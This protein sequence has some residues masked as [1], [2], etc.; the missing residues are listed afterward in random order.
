MFSSRG[1]RGRRSR[2]WLVVCVAAGMVP[3]LAG[4]A[5]ALAQTPIV[6]PQTPPA[7]GTGGNCATDADCL[8]AANAIRAS[9]E[10]LPPLALPSNWTS[11]TAAEQVFVDTNLERAS[12]SLPTIPNLVNTYDAEVQT[13]MQTD[14]D[15]NLAE[16]VGWDSIWAGGNPTVLGAMY[17]WMYD[18]GF[19]SGNLDC[20][21]PTSTDCWGHRNAILDNAGAFIAPNEMDA[22][23]GN[24]QSGVPSYAAAIVQNPN[25]TP[26][27]NIVFTWAQEQQFLAPPPLG[28]VTPHGSAPKLA[29]LALS[30]AAFRALPG[31]KEPAVILNVKQ[32]EAD[33]TL[34]SYTDSE[35]ATT[36][37]TVARA[38]K[39]GAKTSYKTVGS[40]IHTDAK[41]TNRFRF[42]GRLNGVVLSPGTYRLTASPS[43]A[44]GKLGSSHT[45]VF[46][47]KT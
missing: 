36:T 12:R 31:R 32:K 21:S 25:P 22:V 17:G 29:H 2:T 30:P 47:I 20:T 24:D 41:G 14:A 28:G 45:A 9:Q 46:T 33:G 38:T 10:G 3:A 34:V 26:A 35:V 19:G 16:Q 4:A 8:V 1:G 43:S 44:S 5:P 27:A 37:F 13:G 23:V 40:F 42:M 18:D 15:P 6:P 39:A 7:N 11:L